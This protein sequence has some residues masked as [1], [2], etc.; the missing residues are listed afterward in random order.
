MSLPI[1]R[2]MWT[3]Y[4]SVVLGCAG[5]AAGYL[6][7]V[8]LR[9][10]RRALAFLAGVLVLLAALVSPL[11]ALGDTYLFSAHMVQHLLLILV[12][13]PLLIMGLPREMRFSRKA[14]PEINFRA[15]GVR[16]INGAFQR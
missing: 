13:P 6:A 10:T 5:L 11:D 14:H 15:S 1:F 16:S 8:K 4:P 7:L 2:A 3:W 9:P 12:A